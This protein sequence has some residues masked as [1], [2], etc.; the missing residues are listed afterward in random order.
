M[1][2]WDSEVR[3]SEAKRHFRQREQHLQPP[4]AQ[5]MCAVCVCVCVCKAVRYGAG[6]DL[7]WMLYR[8]WIESRAG[9][10]ETWTRCYDTGSGG[11]TLWMKSCEWVHCVKQVELS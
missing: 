5:A 10:L 11:L 1:V 3:L 6:L 2:K 8:K 4:G 9:G 7:F